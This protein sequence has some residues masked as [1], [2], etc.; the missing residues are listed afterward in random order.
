MKKLISTLL[1]MLELTITLPMLIMAARPSTSTTTL[2]TLTNTTTATQLN[3][4]VDEIT[5]KLTNSVR[6]KSRIVKVKCHAFPFVNV[7]RDLKFHETLEY[8]FTV[9]K[10]TLLKTSR[11]WFEGIEPGKTMTYL[12][13]LDY[14]LGLFGRETYFH[15]SIGKHSICRIHNEKFTECFRWEDKR[16]K[17]MKKLISTLF[18]M[19]EL[20]ITLPM[21]IMAARPS[22][23][24][25]ET[26]NNT[27]TATQL[28]WFMDEEFLEGN[29]IDTIA[30][31]RII[32]A[33]SI[34]IISQ[35]ASIGMYIGVLRASGENL[36][37]P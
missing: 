14:S 6:P 9:L 35:N 20:T 13:L 30:S 1:I 12:V 23:T 29:P 34:A 18:I 5:I 19:L 28:N 15:F 32:Y 26:L 4:F 2:E 11:C 31:E 17:L 33:G 24:T 21:L 22:T 16:R 10:G 37:N 7:D 36:V 25:L 8:K 3:W 27:T